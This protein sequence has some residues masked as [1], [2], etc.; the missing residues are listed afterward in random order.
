MTTE[1]T[2][3]RSP[4]KERPLRDAG[5]SLG[6][7]VAERSIDVGGRWILLPG[8]FVVIAVLEWFRWWFNLEAAP[9]M[10]TGF[11]CALVIVAIWRIRVG[12]SNLEQVK[13]GLR[14]ERYVGQ[15]L[16]N[17][18]LPKGYWVI[19]DIPFDNGGNPFNVDHAVI[20]PTGV[21][22]VETKTR[23]KPRGDAKIAYDGK[24]ILVCG[25]RPDR[26]PI[27]QAEANAR[28]LIG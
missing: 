10:L 27:A 18:L 24:Q 17:E 3:N 13:L 7:H 23:S 1:K 12:I 2:N 22:A 28:A 20:G 25:H 8:F 16:Q 19:H 5:Q 21:Y 11:A 15:F 4:I 6:R 14:G 26:D 9:A